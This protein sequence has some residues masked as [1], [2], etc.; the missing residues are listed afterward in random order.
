MS[1]GNPVGYGR[2]VAIGGSWGGLRATLRLLAHVPA[3]FPVPV[4]LVL[5]RATTSDTSLLE[6]VIQRDCGHRARE[7]GDKDALEPGVVGLAPPDYHLLV[8]GRTVSLSVEAHV[9]H[10]RPS[11]DL[12][13]ES[14]ARDYGHDLTAVLLSGLGRDGVSGL[15]AVRQE[16][17]QVLVQDP[18]EAERPD[19]PSAAVAAGVASA[20]LPAE[21]IGALL[22]ASVEVSR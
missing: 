20:I 22:A 8:E 6:H 16:G 18:A 5:H 11:I 19:M 13:F 7:L 10:S 15:A 17:G 12:A 14:A 4:L 2:L 1:K 21:A 9:Q 3:P